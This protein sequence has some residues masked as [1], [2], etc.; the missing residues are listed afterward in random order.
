TVTITAIQPRLRLSGTNRLGFQPS[1]AISERWK[2]RLMR[3]RLPRRWKN[4]I[5]RSRPS[6]HRATRLVAAMQTGRN[7]QNILLPQPPLQASHL[8]IKQA[9]RET[10]PGKR[11]CRPAWRKTAK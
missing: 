7:K 5:N 6:Q 8:K 11:P 10:M 9:Q 1:M 3:V 4:R 2:R